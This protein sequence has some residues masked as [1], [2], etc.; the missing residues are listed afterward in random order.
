MIRF[1]FAFAVRL[2]FVP[3]KAKALPVSATIARPVIDTHSEPAPELFG[4]TE[5]LA[6]VSNGRAA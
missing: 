1:D 6:S 4:K 2:Q 5:L 3:R